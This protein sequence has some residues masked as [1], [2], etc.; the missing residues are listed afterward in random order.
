M[1]IVVS[2]LLLVA[3]GSLQAQTRNKEMLYDEKGIKFSYRYT[4]L[5]ENFW[6]GGDFAIKWKKWRVVARLEN[7][8]GKDILTGVIYVNHKPYT[9]RNN[10]PVHCCMCGFNATIKWNTVLK[11][12]NYLEDQYELLTPKNATEF[13]KGDGYDAWEVKFTWVDN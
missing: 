10:F 1:K 5:D 2:L 12:G 9:T 4:L 8:S 3:T 11:S 13:P 7:E 6:C